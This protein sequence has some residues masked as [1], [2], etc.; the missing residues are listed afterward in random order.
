[1]DSIA[2]PTPNPRDQGHQ[3]GGT[4]S[5]KRNGSENGG[6]A[7]KKFKSSKHCD[8]CAKKGGP[9]DT[10]NNAECRKWNPDGPRKQYQGKSEDKKTHVNYAQFKEMQDNVKDMS[11]EM[12]RLMKRSKEA[13]DS[14]QDI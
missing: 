1:M 5:K 7:K 3:G 11:K 12:K 2:K 4:N 6:R 14:D 13:S 10:H 8:Y 9:K